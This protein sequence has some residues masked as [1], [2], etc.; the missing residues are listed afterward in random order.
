MFTQGRGCL[1][2]P[3]PAPFLGR[4]P[5]GHGEAEGDWRWRGRRPWR[6]TRRRGRHEGSGTVVPLHDEAYL[7]AICERRPEEPSR[8]SCR[9]TVLLHDRRIVPSEFEADPSGPDRMQRPPSDLPDGA[10]QGDGEGRRRRGATSTSARRSPSPRRGRLSCTPRHAD[11]SAGGRV[12]D[13]EPRRSVPPRPSMGREELGRASAPLPTTIDEQRR[14][15]AIY[16][17]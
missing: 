9:I 13:F 16:E 15:A 2:P 6:P 11:R 14:W 7:S 17:Q 4:G 1:E 8:G 12:D 5:H 10:R 3:P